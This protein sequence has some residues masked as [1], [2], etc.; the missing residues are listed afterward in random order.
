MG[1][2]VPYVFVAR[3]GASTDGKIWSG[4]GKLVIFS[5]KFRLQ[6]TGANACDRA[7]DPLHALEAETMETIGPFW[8]C[9]KNQGDYTSLFRAILRHNFSRC[10]SNV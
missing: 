2:R 6:G 3:V 10:F 8:V 1:E 9:P 5:T 4:N 7:E